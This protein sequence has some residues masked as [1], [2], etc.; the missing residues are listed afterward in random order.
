MIDDDDDD[1]EDADVVVDYD[2]H[3]YLYQIILLGDS[4]IKKVSIVLV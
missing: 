1:D 3:C 4:F 2:R